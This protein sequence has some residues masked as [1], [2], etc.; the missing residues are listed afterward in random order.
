MRSLDI[1]GTGMQAQQTNVEVISNNIANL[2]TTGFKRQRA[3]FQDLIYQSLRRIGSNSSDNGTIVPSGTQIGLGVKTASV[4]RITEQGNLQQ[5]GN[6]LDMA[7]QGNGYFQVT[8]PTGETAY[9]RDGTFALSPAGQIVT[10]DGYTVQP[11]ITVPTNATSISVNGSGQV[12]ATIAGQT[13]PATLGQ[14][15][16]AAFPNPAG[17]E[18][19]GNN[20]F[21]E[22]AASGNAATGAPASPGFGGTMQGF[23]RI[24]E[25]E[26]GDRNHQPDQRSARLRN[27]QQG[28]H[29]IRR[30]DADADAI[31]LSPIHTEI[32]I[33]AR[34][35]L[36]SACT[37]IATLIV[38]EAG[39]AATLRVFRM[40][41]ADTVRL[42]DLF[43]DLGVSDHV[44]GAAPAPGQRILVEAPQ[45]AAIAR[46]Y[47]V[48]WRPVSG[49]EQTTLQRDATE[50]S[51]SDAMALL[52]PKLIAAGAGMDAALVLADY[53]TPMLPRGSVPRAD[54]TNIEYDAATAKF[55]ALLTLTIPD[56]P[57]TITRLAGQAISMVDAVVL[58]Q[59]LN[60]GTVL[61]ENM[62]QATRIAASSLHGT[63][64]V[65]RNAVLGL[66]LKRNFAGGQP[67]TMGDLTRPILVARNATVRMVLSAGQIALSAEGI[68]LEDGAMGA[69]IRVQ[70]PSS[71]AV[72]LAEITGADEVRIMPSRAPVQVAAQ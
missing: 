71:R 36:L 4:Y 7:I 35:R 45:L 12:Q 49:A 11:G 60:A 22:T 10:A 3:E 30:H 26:R 28:H 6:N 70:N 37:L 59:P 63:A 65:A 21:L 25:R 39:H 52:R 15:Q 34:A 46:D 19:E 38:P 72:V 8:L 47:N 48:D 57:P 54:I 61:S 20:L 18:A 9:T 50:F 29:V 27:E 16:L 68:A 43:D 44:L 66:A 1:A 41:P 55:T 24:L 33:M 40:L 64:A 53:Q 31:A 13:A 56:A 69:H 14:I 62:L 2:S 5:T 67:L 51:Q 42:S 17:L 58:T 23:R 32:F